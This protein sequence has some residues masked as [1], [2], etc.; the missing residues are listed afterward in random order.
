MARLVRP[1][2]FLGPVLLFAG[3]AFLLAGYLRGEATLS[4]FVIF[5][6]ITATG[7]WSALGILL[8]IAGFFAFF[9]TWPTPAPAEIEPP[10]NPDPSSPAAP[11]TPTRRWGGVIFLGPFPLVFGSDMK[12]ARWMLI[13]G[14][15]LFVGLLVLTVISVW[16]I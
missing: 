8:L 16:G 9:L 14:V 15:L 3:A 12:V 4:L 10:R 13:A 2:R 1:S 7:A 11:H 6:V 5:P